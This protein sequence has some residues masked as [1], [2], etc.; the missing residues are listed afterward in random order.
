LLDPQAKALRNKQ[1]RDKMRAK[2]RKERD[3]C[4]ALGIPFGKRRISKGR[5]RGFFVKKMN[6]PMGPSSVLKNA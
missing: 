6:H 1:F 3:Q 2:V 4:K 5:K